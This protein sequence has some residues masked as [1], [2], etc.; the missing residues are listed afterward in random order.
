MELLD[1]T[2]LGLKRSGIDPFY[3]KQGFITKSYTQ[4]PNVDNKDNEYVSQLQASSSIKVN[5]YSTS[6]YTGYINLDP[7]RDTVKIKA[8]RQVKKYTIDREGV[9]NDSDVTLQEFEKHVKAVPMSDRWAGDWEDLGA[10]STISAVKGNFSVTMDTQPQIKNT[11]QNQFVTRDKANQFDREDTFIDTNAF[12]PSRE[13]IFNAEGLKPNTVM[14]AMFDHRDVTNNCIQADDTSGALTFSSSTNGVLK[15]DGFGLLRG[16][17]T[18]PANTYKTGNHI[19][20]LKDVTSLSTAQAK[21]IAG[22]SYDIGNLSKFRTDGIEDVLV[23]TETRLKTSN[24]VSKYLGRVIATDTSE[25]TYEGDLTNRG[26]TQTSNVMDDIH[27]ANNIADPFEPASNGTLDY[28]DFSSFNGYSGDSGIEGHVQN[29][30]TAHVNSMYSNDQEG[31]GN[32]DGEGHDGTDGGF[33]GPDNDTDH[34]GT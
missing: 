7:P 31:S 34:G 32:N 16:K 26:V 33:G 29:L 9:V 27:A 18:I 11:F 23:S 21:Y 5:P 6:T 24:K 19:F 20:T 17:F 2:D 13:I 14:T 1:S 8:S 10:V 25:N 15:T 30:H 22:S 3:F 28:S 4:F 12:I